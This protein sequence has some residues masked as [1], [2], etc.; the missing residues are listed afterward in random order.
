MSA[1]SLSCSTGKKSRCLPAVQLRSRRASDPRFL[2][3]VIARWT[4]SLDAPSTLPIASYVGRPPV[5]LLPPFGPYRSSIHYSSPR[6]SF[7]A[8]KV[9]NGAITGRCVV[10]IL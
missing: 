7:T 2:Y 6:Y 8:L 1:I 4:W 3:V 5:L 9:S 10:D